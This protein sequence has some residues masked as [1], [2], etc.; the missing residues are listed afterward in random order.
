MNLGLSYRQACFNCDRWHGPSTLVNQDEHVKFDQYSRGE[1]RGGC[2]DH[3]V[4][5]AMATCG[6]WVA[7]ESLRK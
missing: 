1:C 6:G 2:F 5:D 4:T 7:W 3:S